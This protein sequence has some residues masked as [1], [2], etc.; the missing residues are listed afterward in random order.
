MRLIELERYQ[1]LHFLC[2]VEVKID[3]IFPEERLR[4]HG[5][6]DAVARP[7]VVRAGDGRKFGVGLHVDARGSAIRRR[8]KALDLGLGVTLECVG[9]CR[10]A[11]APALTDTRQFAVP[12]LRD[13]YHTL[14]RGASL[15]HTWYIVILLDVIPA[16]PRKLAAGAVLL[17]VLLGP[18][19]VT[20]HAARQVVLRVPVALVMR[21]RCRGSVTVL[22]IA[23]MRLSPW[24]KLAYHHDQ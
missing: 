20:R 23:R 13:E 2:K 8:P 19:V 9:R 15:R 14:M 5:P 10:E 21:P 3:L 1:A 18:N 12:A 17:R 22:R 6:A 4:V 7:T 11:T 16:L 24:I